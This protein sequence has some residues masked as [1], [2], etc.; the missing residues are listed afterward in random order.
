M[1]KDSTENQSEIPLA[2]DLAK[3]GEVVFCVCE[4]GSTGPHGFPLLRPLSLPPDIPPPYVVGEG[5]G[6]FC[7]CC[8]STMPSLVFLLLGRLGLWVPRMALNVEVNLRRLLVLGKNDLT[9][10][11]VKFNLV[12]SELDPSS[13]S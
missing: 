6:V 9:S 8:E 12:P 11:N 1:P 4:I 2:S 7:I 5:A 10:D 3:E 13:P